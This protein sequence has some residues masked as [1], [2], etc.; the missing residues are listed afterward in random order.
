MSTSEWMEAASSRTLEAIDEL[1]D[2][3]FASPSSLPGWTIGHIVAHLHFNA[4]AIGRLVQWARSG[5][6]T[7]MYSSPTQRG[8]D[9]EA[10]SSLPPAQLR[11]MVHHSADKLNDAF[12]ALTPEM[13]E[14]QVVTA[15]G[16]TVPATELVWMRFREVAIHGIDL[17]TGLSFT[18]LPT[19][20]VAKLVEEIVAKRLA[21]GEAPALAAIL[22]GRTKAGPPI[23][24]WL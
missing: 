13:W 3:T 10:G 20:A 4:E 7:P 21:A 22:T 24:P 12:D 23:G 19:E 9:I 8:A 15:Q 18:D 6:E 14:H 11:R 1:D 16:R 17:G 2:D 5:V